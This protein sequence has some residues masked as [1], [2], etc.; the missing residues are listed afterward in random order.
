MFNGGTYSDDSGDGEAALDIDA[1]VA[2][3]APLQTSLYISGDESI[4]F[5]TSTF[6]YLL[7]DENRPAVFS[8]SYGIEETSIS[9]QSANTMC[10][11]AKQLTALGVTLVVASGDNGVN[12]GHPGQSDCPPFVPTYPSGC[13]YILSVGATSHFGP[14]VS[15]NNVTDHYFGGGGFSNLFPVPDYQKSATSGY[16]SKIGNTDQGEYNAAG[17][18]FP[19]VS[20]QGAN[21]AIRLLGQDDVESGTSASAPAF[22][23]VLALIN[24]AR[25]AAGKG[26]LGWVNPS[27]YSN[28]SAFT[29]VTEGGSYGCNNGDGFAALPGWDPST[30]LGTPNFA[31]RE[32]SA[33]GGEEDGN[34]FADLECDL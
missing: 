7:E 28:P 29:D 23:A 17:R 10:Q 6:K 15:V 2:T 27:L 1:I 8:M 32:L 18:G 24:S 19:D 21:Y 3:V 11:Y 12:G 31:K 34:S 4:D 33:K 20:A 30:G 5:F 22:S 14:E 9:P 26:L 25:K 16:L 13:P